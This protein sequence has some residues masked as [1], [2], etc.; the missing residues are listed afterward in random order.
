MNHSFARIFLSISLTTV[1]ICSLA[2]GQS[3]GIK[4]VI[5]KPCPVACQTLINQF[6]PEDATAPLT[7]TRD[8][9]GVPSI[10]GGTLAEVARAIG[11]VQAE[12]RLWQLFFFN[13]AGNGRLAQYLG[14][15]PGSIFLQSDIFRRTI[16]YTD[17]EIQDQIDTYFT[18]NT[19]TVYEN[20]VLGLNDVVN[21][22][23][24]NPALRPY[25]F[26]AIGVIP[27]PLFTI[28]D[29]LRT[30][31]F[32]L[33]RFSSSSVP[34]YQLDD[35]TDLQTLIGTQGLLPAFAIF[36][37]LFPT[38]LQV[39]SQ[40]TVVPNTICNQFSSC[41]PFCI[42][43]NPNLS[44]QDLQQLQTLVCGAKQVADRLEAIKQALKDL[45]MPKLGSNGQ[46]IS[47][48][49]SA[50]GK[51]MIRCAVQPGFDYP[52]TFYQA[53]IESPA[54]GIKAEYFT[55]PGIPL[56][57]LGV[58]NNVGITVQVGHLPT[59]DFLF[60]STDNVDPAQTRQEVIQVLASP[61]V[62]ITVQRSTSGGFVIQNPVSAGTMLTLRTVFIGLQLRAANAAV[63]PF[64]FQ[65]L[66]VLN[67]GLLNPLYQ[68][69]LVPF[70]GDYVDSNGNIAAFHCGGWTQLPAPFDNRLPQGLPFNPAPSNDVY[71]I[72][73]IGRNPLLN[74]NTKQGYYVGWNT[75]F[76]ED[77]PAAV[78]RSL[79]FIGL[80]R[81]Y[82]LDEYLKSKT[83]VTFEDLKNLS[84]HQAV[85]NGFSG[86]DGRMD[87]Y[88]DLFRVLFKERFFE[89][90][91]ANPT[92]TRLQ[93]LALLA[94]YQGNWIDG[95]QNNIV[96]GTDVSD[97]YILAQVWL[98]LVMDT[99]LNPFLTGT[100]MAVYVPTIPNP[101]PPYTGN[102]QQ[103]A[104][105]LSRILDLAC[106]NTVFFPAWLTGQDVNDVIVNALDQ[107]LVILGGFAAQPWGAGLRPIHQFTS[108]IL[109][110]VQTTPA[111][112]AGG[113]NFVAEFSACGA[114]RIE[115]I[116]PLG[117]SGFSSGTPPGA[118]VFNIHNFDQEPL[119]NHLQLRA[120]PP[121]DQIECALNNGICKKCGNPPAFGPAVCN[122]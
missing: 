81:V 58:I 10:K 39:D 44:E 11:Q 23:N 104:N 97:P 100:N 91:Q 25:E 49:K 13:I 68:S 48:C 3:S 117:E 29:I 116:I 71:N 72:D 22:I 118:P 103:T 62:V 65:G 105:L 27:I 52:S 21:Q 84:F 36:N 20:Y 90:V 121:F 82:W 30:D 35:L 14:A 61:D 110:T 73:V 28:Y 57:P 19:L 59:N 122:S 92:P 85:A 51:P 66:D 102:L 56:A 119:F 101:L 77:F 98:L 37:D 33:Q 69:D 38:S 55:V 76:N 18:P 40:Y 113:V 16:N 54:A 67:K 108:P 86:F 94:D 26:N 99:I 12:D 34:Q 63:E 31:E 107:A 114:T 120:L 15:G 95:D 1:L 7:I 45:G 88:A 115:S 93:A 83:K 32:I 24:L 60:E 2:Q 96:N 106:D 8:G 75:L 17:A 74:C 42:R 87:Y 80:N 46:V 109:G 112:N 6:C 53:R 89:A 64:F 50:S 79:N 111:F 70:A 43:S 47:G 5:N 4:A 9:F 41:Q 78:D